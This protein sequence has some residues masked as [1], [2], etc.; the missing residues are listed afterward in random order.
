MRVTVTAPYSGPRPTIA[1]PTVARSCSGV[2][3]LSAGAAVAL[4]ASFYEPADGCSLPFYA[5]D[6]IM[7]PG[8]SGNDYSSGGCNGTAAADLVALD[9]DGTSFYSGAEVDGGP[10][11]LLSI[12]FVPAPDAGACGV[13]GGC[14]DFYAGTNQ[15]F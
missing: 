15:K 8:Y 2:A 4:H 12:K 7:A 13:S 5:T 11:W 1:D 3:P 6:S 14:T 9:G 10:R